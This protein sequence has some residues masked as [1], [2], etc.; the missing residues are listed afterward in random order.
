LSSKWQSLAHD[1]ASKLATIIDTAP[2]VPSSAALLKNVLLKIVTCSDEVL[3]APPL[4]LA[5][6]D[7]NV[8]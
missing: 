5:L 8:Q 4:I 7:K 6:L 1:D 3:K 2:P